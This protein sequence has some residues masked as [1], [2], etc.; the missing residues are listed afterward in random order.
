MSEPALRDFGPEPDRAALIDPLTTEERVHRT[1]PLIEADV[2]EELERNYYA[3]DDVFTVMI[4]FDGEVVG[5]VRAE[6]A[7]LDPP[8]CGIP[9]LIRQ[10]TIRLP[11]SP[12]IPGN[13]RGC[14]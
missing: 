5:L 11:K 10:N 14:R 3:G 6:A 2:V 1:R 8:A 12:L 7:T 9:V 4:E 13:R